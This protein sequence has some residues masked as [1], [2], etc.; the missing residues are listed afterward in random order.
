MPP[1]TVNATADSNNDLAATLLSVNEALANNKRRCNEL[2][3][4]EV[5][6]NAARIAEK[7][8]EER[9]LETEARALE[10]ANARMVAFIALV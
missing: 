10:A 1:A 2:M 4:A 6:K 8:E 5:D 7:R 9:R 3:K